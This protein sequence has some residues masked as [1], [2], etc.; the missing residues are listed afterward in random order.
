MK[1]KEWSTLQGK[2]RKGK[3]NDKLSGLHLKEYGSHESTVSQM[4]STVS[5]MNSNR[6]IVGV[7]IH[8]FSQD[9]SYNQYFCTL[10]IVHEVVL[11]TSSKRS[12]L[13]RGANYRV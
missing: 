4:N 12:T 13:E 7:M 10:F 5:Q 11:I 6:Q 3:F 8:I 9:L 2:E 1:G